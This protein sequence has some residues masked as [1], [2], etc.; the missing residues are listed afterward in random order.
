MS[1]IATL[2]TEVETDVLA[3][4]REGWNVVES[5]LEALLPEVKADLG[6]LLKEIEVDLMQGK[7]VDEMV[8]AMLNL[9]EAKGMALVIEIST[10]V[11][12]GLAAALLAKI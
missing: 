9:A 5:A 6:A 1:D 12:S 2:L 7:S 8:T 4:A 3:A 10:D 11:L